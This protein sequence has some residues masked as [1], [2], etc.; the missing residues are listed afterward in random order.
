MKPSRAAFVFLLLGCVALFACDESSPAHEAGPAFEAND[1][2]VERHWKI[3]RD[4]RD[5][6]R[7]PANFER[8]PQTGL[9]SMSVPDISV[10]LAY[11]VAAGEIAHAD[12]VLPEVP[13]SRTA[14]KY[15][16]AWAQ[17]RDDIWEMT[18]QYGTPF[19]IAAS[20]FRVG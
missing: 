5:V 2:E 15:W 19:K 9:S 18:G 7:N 8:D 20:G 3:V 6:I 17:D 13:R 10:S 11:L 4:Y 14:V 12:V 16:L 1:A